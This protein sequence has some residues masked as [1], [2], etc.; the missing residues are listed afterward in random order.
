MDDVAG[1]RMALCPVLALDLVLRFRESLGLSGKDP[2][3]PRLDG[4]ATSTRGVCHA[5]TS[6]LGVPVTEHSFRREGAQYFTRHG[7]AEAV[8][9]F[10]GRWGSAAVK[11]YI[12][13]AIASVASMAA[14][15]AAAS[16]SRGSTASRFVREGI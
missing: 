2:L 5:Y 3:F 11:R 10:I 12:D 14:R 15:D 8:V 6:L 9:M 16:I 4:S 1:R 13:D 7:V